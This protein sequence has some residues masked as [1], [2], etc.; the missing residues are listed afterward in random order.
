MTYLVEADTDTGHGPVQ[1]HNQTWEGMNVRRRM[2]NSD[3]WRK[4][5]KF[6]TLV[7]NANVSQSLQAEVI[8]S[9]LSLFDVVYFISL[10]RFSFMLI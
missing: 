7:T 10:F 9:A 4:L 6:V 8:D 2:V 3:W 1:T 5:R